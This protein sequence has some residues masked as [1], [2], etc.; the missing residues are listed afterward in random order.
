MAQIGRKVSGWGWF[1][2]ALSNSSRAKHLKNLPKFQSGSL[3]AN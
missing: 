3:F 1:D 2:P